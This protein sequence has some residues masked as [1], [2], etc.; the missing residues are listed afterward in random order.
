MRSPAR[1]GSAA[2]SARALIS[3]PITRRVLAGA[4]LDAL[5][6]S[7]RAWEAAAAQ[8]GQEG[9]AP[10]D[11]EQRAESAAADDEAAAGSCAA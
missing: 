6:R 9:D 11:A 4:L 1:P 3:G 2:D 10:L 7:G 5:R 8:G